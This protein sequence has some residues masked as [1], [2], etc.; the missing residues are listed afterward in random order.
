MCSVDII[1]ELRGRFRYCRTL[2]FGRRSVRRTNGTPIISFSFDDFPS[3]ALHS[4]GGILEEHGMAGTYYAALSLMNTDAPAGR[5]FSE[6]ELHQVLARGHELGCHTFDH[7]DAWNTDPSTFESS[8]LRNRQAL[9]RLLPGA[10]FSTLSYPMSNPRPRTKQKVEK[11]FLG[12]RGCSQKFN[13]ANIDLNFLRA[14]F[15]EQSRG[16][17]AAVKAIIDRNCRSTGWLIFAT[18]DVTDNPSRFGC[19]PAFFREVV[20][21]AANSGATILPVGAALQKIHGR[22]V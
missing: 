18:H 11:Y 4:G 15:L 12:C 14:F 7:C 13:A 6:A 20:R 1:S 19:T 3:S 17:A 9:N 22:G 8:I 16:N 21:Y 10:S 5:I 2:L